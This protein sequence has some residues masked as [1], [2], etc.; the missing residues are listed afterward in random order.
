MA[1]TIRHQPVGPASEDE[2]VRAAASG[3]YGAMSHRPP[4]RPAGPAQQHF[5]GF[6]LF[7]CFFCVFFFSVI[8]VMVSD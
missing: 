4:Q 5:M 1:A 6:F 8:P 2:G 3:F 7:V